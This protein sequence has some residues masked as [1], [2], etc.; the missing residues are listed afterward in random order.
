MQ[1][2][3]LSKTIIGGK[4]IAALIDVIV[5]DGYLSMGKFVHEFESKVK[6]YLGNKREVVCVN[7]GTAALHLAL[8]GLKLNPGD[9]VLVQSLTYVAVYQAISATGLKPI[10]CEI[11]QNGIIDLNDAEKKITEKT[12]VILPVHYASRTGDL[13]KIYEFAQK[14]NLRVVEDAAHAFGSFYNGQK[15]GSF[16]DIACFSFDAIKNITCGEGGAIVTNDAQ[17]INFAKNARLLGINKDTDQRFKN[18]RSWEFDVFHQGYRYHMTNLSASLGLAQLERLDLEFKPKRQAQAKK[19]DQELKEVVG[20]EL[21]PNDYDHIIPH[22]FPIKV[23]NNQR[24]SLREYLINN[25]VECGIHYYPNHWLTFYGKH[26][27]ELPVTEKFYNEILSI[28]LH[29]DVT[30]EQQCYVIQKI[31]EFNQNL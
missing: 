21:L 29:P 30:Y 26:N 14:H 5:N 31:K 12:K 19:Y 6:N 17:V 22:I 28:P 9:E 15:V 10:S 18:Q 8:M 7:S 2:V 23:K 16:G 3:Q 20:L 4:E 11:D 24:D 27:G 1:K 13:D 25:N